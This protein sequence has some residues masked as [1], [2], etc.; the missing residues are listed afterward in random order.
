[1]DIET[2]LDL[3]RSEPSEEIITLDVLRSVLE[4]EQSPKHYIGFEISGMPHIALFLTAKKINDMVKAGVKTQIL[5]ADWHTVANNKLGGDWEKIKRAAGF[6][7]EVFNEICPKTKVIMG[8]ELYHNND[9]FWKLVM[10]MARRTTMARATRTLIIEGRSEKDTLYVSQYI[11][12]IMQAADIY[13]LDAKIANAGIDQRKV[14]ML[15]KELFKDIGL[16][17]FAAV[18]QHLLP[19]LLEPPKINNSMEKEEIVAE[20]KMSKSKPGSAVPIFAAEEEIRK[21]MGGAWCPERVVQGNPVLEL[22]RYLLFPIKGGLKIERSSKYGG[23]VEY[24]DYAGLERDYREGKLHPADLKNAIA[25]DL[26]GI[27]APISSKFS[28]DKEEMLKI[29]S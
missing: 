11:Y 24:V 21:T 5:L 22:C 4:A 9:E 13:A 3:I 15:A 6:Y 23:D 25:R 12:P 14:H 1:M 28:K 26:N 27:I 16:G 2:R 8:S 20:M 17:E 7:R 19:S 29:L 18:H 10:K